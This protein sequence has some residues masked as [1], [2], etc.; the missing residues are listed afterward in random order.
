MTNSSRNLRHAVRFTLAASALTAA[1]PLANAQQQQQAGPSTNAP[2][3]AV[4]EVVVTGSRI[5]Q[6]PNEVSISP[7][8]S[9]TAIDIQQTGLTRTE[10]LLNNLPQVVAEQ[11]SGLSI[12]SFGTATVSLRGLGSDRT[13]VLINGRRMQPG[14][15]LGPSSVADVDQIPAEL[16]ERLDVLTGGASAVYGADAVAGVVNFVLNKK[17]EGV[18]L[19]ANYSFYNHQNGSGPYD[20]FLSNAGIPLPSGTVNT[21][22]SK[23]LSF[24]AGS[25]FADGKGNATVYVT[26]LNSLPVAGYQIDHAACTLNGPSTIVAG[27]TLTKAVT[28]GGSST[29]A[30]GRFFE[31]GQV[32]GSTSVI[33]NNTVDANTNQFRPYHHSDSYNYGALS[34]FQ[35]QAERWTAG[36]FLDYDVNDNVNVYSET[37]FARNSTVAQYGPSGAFAFTSFVTDCNN[38]LIQGNPSV[39]AVLCNPTTVAENQAFF[40]SPAGGSL[41][42]TGT[43]FDLYLGRRNVEGGG[44]LDRYQSDS[45]RQVIGT[46]GKFADAWS[47]DVYGQVGIT[48]FSDNEGGFLGTQQIANALQAVTNPATG[49]PTCASV[50]NGTDTTCVPWNIYT[51]GGVT[52][53]QLN[54]LTVPSS[55]QTKSLEYVVDGSITGD[56]TKYGVKLPSAASGLQ[57]NL[58][59][60]YRQETYDFAPDYIFENGFAA[61]GNGAQHPIHG[62]FHVSEVFTELH[63]PLVDEKPGFYNLSVEGGF[64]YSSYTSGFNTNTYKFGVEWAP[65]QDVRFRAGY[66]RAIRAPNIGDLYS[67][68]VVGAGGTADPCWGPTPAYTLAQCENTGVT[69]AEYGHIITNPAAQINTQA[70]G[71]ASLRPETADTYSFGVVF[72]PTSINGLVV[73]LDYFDIKIKNTIQALTSNTVLANCANTGDAQLCGL[74]HRGNGGSLWFN[75]NEFVVTTEQ[76]IGTVSTAGIDLRGNY[77]MD[78]GAWGKLAF[79]LTGTHAQSFVTQPLPTGGS[80]DCVGYWGSTCNAPE[81]KWR[82][83]LNSTWGTPW[84]GLDLTLRWRYIGGS[85]VDRSSPN[86]LLA[87]PYYVYT[88]HIPAY[89]YFDLSAS[90]PVTNSISF[91]LGV[92]NIAD[93][94]PPLVLNG[95]YSDCPNTTCND[96]TWAGTYDALGRY[97]YAHISAKF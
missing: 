61:G 76:N 13:L 23:D 64:R 97:I 14:G 67:P 70:G 65:V 2:P 24:V 9:V 16:I 96:N 81:P 66:N 72:Q 34:Y 1:A 32:D 56:F 68:T 33:V 84:G 95:S 10:D 6:S 42:L 40:N 71:N 3:V 69:A 77:R 91:R 89:S 74:I 15:G 26:Y 51:A 22:Q 12:S 21:G 11:S 59:A 30:T 60:E 94:N 4:Q 78:V 88:A 79:D 41:G 19:D 80:F 93:K 83:V 5:Q 18:K 52:Q 58:G 53:A 46:K 27:A 25:N 29:S 87:T 55:W 17:Y 90:M 75:N 8:T 57:L 43:Q 7:V 82:H 54:Y 38:P 47:Y 31:L 44:R 63:L 62:E 50:L 36:A 85:S 92:N 35:R 28:C 86:P 48:D 45:I 37:M 39:A 20:Y 49:Q 73:S